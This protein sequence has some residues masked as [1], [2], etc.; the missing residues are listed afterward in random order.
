MQEHIEER[1]SGNIGLSPLRYILGALNNNLR[2][3]F[4]FG[5]GTAGIIISLFVILAAVYCCYVYRKKDIDREAV[6]LFLLIAFVPLV[7]FM[8]LTNHSF[9]H[10]FFTYRAL[11]ATALS[12]CILIYCIVDRRYFKRSR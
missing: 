8:I 7:R 3:L 2:C 9:I 1:T 6:K 11:S 12:L 10:Y 4:P 5:Y